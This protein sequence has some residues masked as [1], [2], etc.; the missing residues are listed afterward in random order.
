MA[1]ATL[2]YDLNDPEDKQAHLRAIMS[3]DLVLFMWKYDQHLRSE[4]KHGGNEGAYAYREKFIEMMNEY[5][6]DLDQ[7]LS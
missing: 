1:T 3:L 5:N 4:Y 2:T 6:I 7:L